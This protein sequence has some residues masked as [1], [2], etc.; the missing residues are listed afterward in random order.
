M[1]QPR[2]ILGIDDDE[3]IRGKVPMTK[4]EIRILTLTKAKIGLDDVVFDIGAGTGS[5]SIEAA[6]LAEYGHVYAIEKNPEGIELIQQN[7]RKFLVDNIDVITGEAPAAMQ[8]LPMCDA[9]LIGGSGKRLDTILNRVD[10][11]LKPQGRIVLNCITIQTLSECLTYMKQHKEYTYEAMQVQI[12][13]LHAVGPYDMAQALNPIY[14]V[15]CT[16]QAV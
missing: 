10:T 12:N 1:K 6:L 7:V 14:I 8:N 15:T 13:R 2:H 3:F 4:Q 5:L 11:L 9:V 16:K